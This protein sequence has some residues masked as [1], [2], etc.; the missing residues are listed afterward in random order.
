MKVIIF[1]YVMLCA[2]VRNFCMFWGNILPPALI[3]IVLVNLH[4]TTWCHSPEHNSYNLQSL[5]QKPCVSQEWTES[6]KCLINVLWSK[7]WH[8]ATVT[9]SFHLHSYT[10]LYTGHPS[11]DHAI[12][13]YEVGSW[14]FFVF[15]LT[16][17]HKETQHTSKCCPALLYIQV[18]T[19]SHVSVKL[20]GDVWIFTSFYHQYQD[21]N[22][23]RHCYVIGLCT[24]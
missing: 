22:M 14:S 2:V 15:L 16:R 1:L 5:F 17:L 6:W 13:G 24:K 23:C 11:S 18:S 4:K 8:A 9:Y 19:A 20:C 10:V 7:V 21:Y 12:L 3:S